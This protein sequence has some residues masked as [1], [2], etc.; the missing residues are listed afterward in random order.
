MLEHA[1]Y[2]RLVAAGISKRVAREKASAA[3]DAL[4]EQASVIRES[5]LNKPDAPSQ[6]TVMSFRPLQQPTLTDFSLEVEPIPRD[7]LGDAIELVIG[8]PV[9]GILAAV[10]VVACGWWVYQNDLVRFSPRPEGGWETVP[11]QIPGVSAEWT[12]WCDTANAG[13]GGVLLLVSL[14]YR[15]HRMAALTLLGSAV[16]VFG[17]KLGIRT[18]EPI[19]DYHV[20]MLLGTVLALVGYRL[21]RR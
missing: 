18:V 16:A 8:K 21:G 14:F 15:G 19:R 13:W 3:A 17:H 10:L 6:T 4:M 1:E 5:E 7:P 9:R 11:L 2:H 20:A 12:S